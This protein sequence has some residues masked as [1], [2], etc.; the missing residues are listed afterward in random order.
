MGKTSQQR[1][2]LNASLLA[3]EV[4][5]AKEFEACTEESMSARKTFKSIECCTAEEKNICKSKRAE[6]VSGE[7]FSLF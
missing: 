5:E 3:N 6:Q 2:V 1:K 4:F 7:P